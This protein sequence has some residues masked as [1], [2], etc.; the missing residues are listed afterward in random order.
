M[1]KDFPLQ[2]PA[3]ETQIKISKMLMIPIVRVRHLV[4]QQMRPFCV[5]PSNDFAISPFIKW[6]S[7]LFDFSICAI[8]IAH[9]LKLWR[10]SPGWLHWK[11]KMAV[12]QDLEQSHFSLQQELTI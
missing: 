5:L 12:V 10:C 6:L 2:N 8:I 9:E 1:K 3:V 11:K 7:S 4:S